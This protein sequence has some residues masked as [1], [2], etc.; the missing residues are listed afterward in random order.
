MERRKVT[1]LGM[2]WRHF[3]WVP[4]IPA[5][6][7]AVFFTLAAMEFANA[8]LL[9]RYGVTVTA[10]V[11]GRD[12]RRSRNQ[13]GQTSTDY[14]VTYRFRTLAGQEVE[15]RESVSRDRYTVLAP[16]SAVEV[17]Y[18]EVDPTVATLD[19][20]SQRFSAWIFVAAGGFAAFGAAVLGAVM[21]GFKRSAL[22]AARD[23]EVRE[24]QVT[25]LNPGTL[26]VNGEL[27]YR[28][29]WRDAAGQTGQSRHHRLGTLPAE[30]SVVVVYV[31][32]VSGRGWWENDL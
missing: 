8:D 5:G 29:D 30:G 19:P 25:A 4:L 20:S 11:T 23:G 9:D 24:A 2:L 15:R 18:A 6:V 16:G 7:A 13:D 21:L 31:D 22:R 26:T 17:T 27:Y 3:L 10:E 12:I 28:M 1:V 14:R 32:P